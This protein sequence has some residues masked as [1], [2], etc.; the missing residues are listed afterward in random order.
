MRITG[1]PVHVDLSKLLTVR[2]APLEPVSHSIS[3]EEENRR[4]LAIDNAFKEAN[5]FNG[6]DVYLVPHFARFWPRRN[7]DEWVGC[8]KRARD[9][10]I[11]AEEPRGT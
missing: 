3:Y 11:Q 8:L 6:R 10:V 7:F 4:F 5:T 9:V 1:V 2:P